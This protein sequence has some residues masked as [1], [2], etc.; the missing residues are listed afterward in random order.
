MLEF[1]ST[2]KHCV[3]PHGFSQHFSLLLH[4]E[5]SLQ[6]DCSKQLLSRGNAL[7]KNGHSPA[8]HETKS[9]VM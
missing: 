8:L 4:S 3:T 1:I 7:G 9:N 6:L 2:S 5:S